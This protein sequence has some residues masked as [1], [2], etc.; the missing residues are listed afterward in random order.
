MNNHYWGMGWGMWIIP[1]AIILIIVFFLRGR[2][3]K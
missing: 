2:R 3:R 1:I